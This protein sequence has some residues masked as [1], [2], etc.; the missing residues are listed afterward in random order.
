M[1]FNGKKILITGHTGFKGSWLTQVLLN[2]GA[3]I[4][5]YSLPPNTQPNLFN[6]LELERKTK[7]YFADIR[8]YAKVLEVMK[9]EKPE[10][11][12]HMAAQP[13]VR[14]SY[15]DPIYTYQT[16]VMGTVN[17]LQAIRETS[18]T[19]A[20]VVVTTDKVYENKNTKKPY[21]E[22]DELGGYD[23]Y[24]ASKVC[25][26][27]VTKSYIRSFFN[28]SDYGTKHN[29]LVCSVR[30]GNVIGGGDWSKDRLIPDIVRAIFEKNEKVILRNPK[31]TR[32]WQHVLDPLW[33]YLLLAQGLY[34]GRKDLATA[35]NFAPDEN[36]IT[37]EEIVKKAVTI[38]GKGSYS[39]EHDKTKHEMR[40]LSLDAGK[41]KKNLAW[42]PK[43][44][45]N[46][47]MNWTFGW[48]REY[49]NKGDIVS[50]TNKQTTEYISR[51][52]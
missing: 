19:K 27:L 47:A 15:D 31:S 26:E 13:L 14:D 35:W 16:N 9:T 3:N 45:N 22:D 43:L 42:R 34:N 10:I 21:K 23:P 51:K 49:Y 36:N 5:G 48:Y 41:A 7:T 38:V 20:A 6:I 2:S 30:A 4:V 50:L 37:V 32:P 25:A 17:V 1:N 52:G 46:D 18:S 24:S 12:I 39:V 28:P 29:T 11:V 8:D 44:D 33:G 40:M